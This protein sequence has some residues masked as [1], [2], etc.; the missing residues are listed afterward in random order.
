MPI[1]RSC[2]ADFS[3]KR[4]QSFRAMSESPRPGVR[5]SRGRAEVIMVWRDPIKDPT[6]SAVLAAFEAARRDDLPQVDCY[7]AGV[8]AWRHAH[9]DQ[10]PKYA[11]LKAVDVIL[12]ARVSLRVDDA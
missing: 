4:P 10:Q 3:L 9:P 1:N 2:K 12:A 8:L 5:L 6:A 11:A 7:R